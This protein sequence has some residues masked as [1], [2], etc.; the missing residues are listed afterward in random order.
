MQ[1]V[2]SPTHPFQL[3]T[4]HSATEVLLR[5]TMARVYHVVVQRRHLLHGFTV[6]R[7][8]SKRIDIHG[9]LCLSL[10]FLD[11]TTF[12]PLG[13]YARG[14]LDQAGGPVQKAIARVASTRR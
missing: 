13:N 9:K 10:G 14:V 11:L 5:A 3:F 4:V 12:A 7:Q 6:K 2:S 1:Y 8:Q